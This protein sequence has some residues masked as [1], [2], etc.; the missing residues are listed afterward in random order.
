[1]LINPFLPKVSPFTIVCFWITSLK[2]TTEER[3]RLFQMV[4]I[5]HGGKKEVDVMLA[6]SKDRDSSQLMRKTERA[7][8][9]K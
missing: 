6:L 8:A 7:R 5:H 1:M 3:K 2:E 9:E 4:M